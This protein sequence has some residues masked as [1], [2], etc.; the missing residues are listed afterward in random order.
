MAKQVYADNVDANGKVFKTVGENIR[1]GARSGEIL[2]YEEILKKIDALEPEISELQANIMKNSDNI[3]KNTLDIT[4]ITN[5]NTL[6][7]YKSRNLLDASKNTNGLLS[8]GVVTENSSYITTDYINISNVNN[9]LSYC[10]IDMIDMPFNKCSFYNL[11]KEY[12]NELTNWES[13]YSSLSLTDVSSDAVFIRLS[14]YK[15]YFND[16]HEYQMIENNTVKTHWQAYFNSYK[17]SEFQP[18]FDKLIDTFGD[19]I[20]EQSMW[21]KYIA[22]ILHT[23]TIFNHGVAGS[24]ISGDNAQSMWQDSRVN[25]LNSDIDCLIIMGG[26]N[27]SADKVTMGEMS[28]TN[29]D[30]NT[31][32]GAYNVLLSKIFYKYYHIGNG[33]EGIVQ[34]NKIN[35]IQIMLTT[36]IYCNNVEYGNIDDIAKTVV[37]IANMW[38]LPVVNQHSK[39]GINSVTSSIYLLDN[40]HP[41]K[42]GGKRMANVFINS[43][44]TSANIIK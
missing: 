27:D 11:N 20:T 42:N 41:N 38:G 10:N 32:V 36:P 13:G 14:F 1:N 23:G 37:D 29:L 25:A 31:F 22:D 30:T 40:V 35:Y 43:L 7:L 34:T 24:S 15:D 3:K 2:N 8:K 44:K 19:S 26:T 6:K 39:S 18:M 17:S 33:F 16:Y 21:Q 9:I 4:S 5:D 28:R 12:I